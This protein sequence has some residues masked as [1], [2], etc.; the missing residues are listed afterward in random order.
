V[1]NP[2]DEKQGFNIKIEDTETQENSAGIEIEVGGKLFDAVKLAV[3]G[4]Y[5]HTWITE[6]TFSQTLH[7]EC[8][9]RNRCWIEA[10]DP[11]LRDT[12]NFTVKL[13]NTTWDLPGV[14]FDSPDPNPNDTGLYRMMQAPLTPSQVTRLRRR[15][16]HIPRLLI[17]RQPASHRRYGRI[18]QPRLH[19]AVSGPQA[20]RPGQVARYRVRLWRSQPGHR[21]V[22]LPRNVVLTATVAGRQVGRWRIRTL[23]MWQTRSVRLA[24]RAPAAGRVC[25]A[26][27]ATATHARGARSRYCATV[28]SERLEL[29]RG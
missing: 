21:P 25:I 10:V 16:V 7:V 23:A 4:H 17:L 14:Y 12:G 13:G 29:A 27:R 3:T 20:P 18:A 22:F 26:V 24:L 8:P 2:T 28:A 9:P 5:N 1:E 11:M 19:V 6:H 15:G